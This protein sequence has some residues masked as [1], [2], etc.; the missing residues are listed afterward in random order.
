MNEIE[1]WLKTRTFSPQGVIGGEGVS[2]ESDQ[3]DEGGY[4]ITPEYYSIGV[5]NTSDSD[6]NNEANKK[7]TPPEEVTHEASKEGV[8]P[9]SAS[10]CDSANL[11]TPKHL[12]F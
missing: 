4:G 10:G 3:Q 12:R 9:V 11:I 7:T 2:N 5:N 8:A 1:K 6:V